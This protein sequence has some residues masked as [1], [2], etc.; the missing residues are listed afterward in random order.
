MRTLFEDAVSTHSRPK[1]AGSK[2]K[3]KSNVSWRFQHTAARRRLVVKARFK[4]LWGIVSTHSRPKAAGCSVIALSERDVVSTHSRPKAAGVWVGIGIVDLQ[5]STHSRPKAAGRKPNCPD[6]VINVS[7]HSRPKA[8]GA[9]AAQTLCR[10]LFQ[11]TAARRRLGR[12]KT[13]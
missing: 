10:E 9:R 6:A 7:T 8:A 5:V 4:V 13:S 1:A 2:P 3:R 12:L 11:H